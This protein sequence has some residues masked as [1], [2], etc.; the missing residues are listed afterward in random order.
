VFERTFVLSTEGKILLYAASQPGECV[1]YRNNEIL[2]RYRDAKARAL[3]VND[4]AS[5]VAVHLQEKKGS[6]IAIRQRKSDY[7]EM[8]D[9]KYGF[10]LRFVG[11]TDI[12]FVALRIGMM[13][14]NTMSVK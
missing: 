11:K 7:Y 13:F 6:F 8:I 14:L 10:R 2:D 12:E 4:D 9:N 1:V 3:A 5:I